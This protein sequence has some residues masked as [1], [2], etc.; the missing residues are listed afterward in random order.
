MPTTI[1]YKGATIAE[2]QAGSIGT[3]S[4]NGKE[5]E[6]DVFVLFENSG[7]IIYGE[8][9]TEAT[10]GD[11]AQL[12]CNGKEMEHDVLVIVDEVAWE[13]PEQSGS[14]LSIT[15]VYSAVQSGTSLE[16]A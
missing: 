16:V 10:A 5:M 7:E 12:V 1:I 4:C 9:S 3:L 6:S 13:N 15:Q 11:I 8:K 2:L 14:T